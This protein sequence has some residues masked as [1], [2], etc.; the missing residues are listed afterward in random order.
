[1]AAILTGR[2]G[3]SDDEGRMSF[4]G[5]GE[6]AR[7]VRAQT[8]VEHGVLAGRFDVSERAQERTR[9]VGAGAAAEAMDGG[10]DVDGD[11]AAVLRGKEGAGLQRPVDRLP[12]F[13]PLPALV[14]HRE[15]SSACPA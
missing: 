11:V 1:M 7:E 4:V 15:Q 2:V 14:E 6:Y 9:T 8:S 10:A 12:N 3:G 5:T 13:G